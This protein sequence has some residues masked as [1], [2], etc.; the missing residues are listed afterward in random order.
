[1]SQ[2]HIAVRS[3]GGHDLPAL[4]PLCIEHAAYERIGHALDRRSHALAAALDATPPRV[5]AWLA[6]SGDDAVGYATATIDFSTLDA[7]P[8]LHMDC[9]YVRDAWR[10]FGIGLRLFETLA[11]F[12]GACACASMQWQT[13]AWNERAAHFYRRLGATELPKRRFTWRCDRA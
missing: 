1:M 4:L 3:A 9:L 6:W 12:A 10:G 11:A 8:F 5:Y 13:P 2:G 7:A